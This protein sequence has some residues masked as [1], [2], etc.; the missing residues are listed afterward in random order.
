M[1]SDDLSTRVQMLDIGVLGR[2]ANRGFQELGAHQG[3]VFLGW[4]GN[5]LAKTLQD[6]PLI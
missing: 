4:A 3:Q 2:L 6:F 5:L 1:S